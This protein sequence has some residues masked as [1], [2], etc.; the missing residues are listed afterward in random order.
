MKSPKAEKIQEIDLDFD[1]EEEEDETDEDR[2]LP[3]EE[4][5]PCLYTVVAYTDPDDNFFDPDLMQVVMD[6]VSI[7]RNDMLKIDHVSNAPLYI[8][9]RIDSCLF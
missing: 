7:S 2:I 1:D 9:L 6:D 5:D 4:I 8:Y 3:D